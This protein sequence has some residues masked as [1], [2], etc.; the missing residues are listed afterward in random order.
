MEWVGIGKLE[1]EI[2]LVLEKYTTRMLLTS[3]N[4]NI[5]KVLENEEGEYGGS[6]ARYILI[7]RVWRCIFEELNEFENKD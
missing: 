3:S 6:A 4:R 5:S 7:E 2:M 1:V